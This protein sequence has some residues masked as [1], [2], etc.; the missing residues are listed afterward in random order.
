MISIKT[1][2]STTT[3]GSISN[4]IMQRYELGPPI[5]S[6]MVEKHIGKE[7]F[8]TGNIYIHKTNLVSSPP[9]AMHLCFKQAQAKM[10]HSPKVSD[11]VDI[12]FSFFLKTYFWPIFFEELQT[13]ITPKPLEL[14]T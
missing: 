3:R 6:I 11:G 1:P 7:A 9:L 2:N 4:K 5:S 8:Q 10:C 14:L 12:F 13:A